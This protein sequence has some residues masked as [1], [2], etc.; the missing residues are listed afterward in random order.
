LQFLGEEAGL[1][2]DSARA[3][4]AV[5]GDDPSAAHQRMCALDA[6]RNDTDFENLATAHKRIKKI[7]QGHE[8]STLQPGLLSEKA[9]CDLHTALQNERVLIDSAIAERDYLTALRAIARLRPVLDRFFDDVMVMAEDLRL[10]NN[11]LALL[12][13]IA[14]L[15]QSIGDFSEIAVA[16]DRLP[17]E[18][19]AAKAD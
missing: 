15:F 19:A 11:R 13:Q 12:Q 18:G 8:P 5:D 9:E 10:R 14:A 2:Q 17:M 3:A 16:S 7:I 6:I 1:R 4:L